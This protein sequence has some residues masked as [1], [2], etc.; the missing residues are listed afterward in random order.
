LKDMAGVPRMLAI[1]RQRTTV[2]STTRN[3]P[4]LANTLT[5]ATS[6]RRCWQCSFLAIHLF[7]HVSSGRTSRMPVESITKD[8]ESS[9]R[10]ACR[11]R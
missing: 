10:S 1:S 2:R 6:S 9:P 5:P 8:R 4:T 7:I 3:A 11:L